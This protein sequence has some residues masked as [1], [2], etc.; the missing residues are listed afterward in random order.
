MGRSRT[1]YSR[2]WELQRVLCAAAMDAYPYPLFSRPLIYPPTSMQRRARGCGLC[3]QI[4]GG[5]A[6]FCMGNFKNLPAATQ[7]HPFVA[8]AQILA[9]GFPAYPALAHRFHQHHYVP[10]T[11]TQITSLRTLHLHPILTNTHCVP[12][13]CI[14]IS[15]LL[16]TLHLHSI[17]PTLT[18]YTSLYIQVLLSHQHLYYIFYILL[19]NF[20]FSNKKNTSLYNKVLYIYISLSFFS[21]F[22]FLGFFYYF[23]IIYLILLYYKLKIKI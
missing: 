1:G 18:L 20:L 16:R 21:P 11:C 19:L 3:R 9:P 7:V 17:L 23:N 22:F 13:T 15:P 14:Q 12:C 2:V 10:C 6:H 5:F 8:R 4:F